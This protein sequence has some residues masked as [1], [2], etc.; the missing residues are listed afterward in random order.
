MSGPQQVKVA[1]FVKQKS[2]EFQ[3]TT[4]GARSFWKEVKPQLPDLPRKGSGN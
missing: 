3:Q 1:S 4:D 2:Q